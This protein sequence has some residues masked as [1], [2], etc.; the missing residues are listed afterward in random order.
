MPPAITH[1]TKSFVDSLTI[2][3]GHVIMTSHVPQVIGA[4]KF[5]EN[6][7]KW[8]DPTQESIQQLGLFG[9]DLNYHTYYPDVT[10]DELHPKDEEFIHPIFR[11]L[12]AT[13]VSKNWNPTDFGHIEG[14][15][16]N[17]MSLLLGQTV[18]CDHSTDIGNAIGSVS[19]V[20]WQEAYKDGKIFIPAGIN[21]VLKID[22]KANP[23][24]ARGI[25]MEPPS[26]H[27]N[28]VTVQFRW[29]K[30]H[31]ELSDSEFYDK[32]GT[33]DSKGALIRRIVTE[34]IRYHETS[35]VSHGA[36]PYAQKINQ[37]GK[38]NNPIFAHRTWNSFAEY[39]DSKDKIYTFE[40][41]KEPTTNDTP[42]DNNKGET[43]SQK[44]SPEINNNSNPISQMDKKLQAFL[45]SLFGDGRLTLAEGQEVTQENALSAISALVA[46]QANHQEEIDAL[47]E[48]VNNLTTERDSLQ[49]QIASLNDK[50]ANLEPMA[51]IGKN[52]LAS[53][54]EQCVSTYQKLK[55]DDADE[56][57]INMLNAE[58]TGIQTLTSLL[59]DYTTRLNEKF[60][61]KCAECGST[62]V[63]R[64]SSVKEG[65]DEKKETTTN[66][67][68]SVGDTISDLYRS[69]LKN[70]K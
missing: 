67:E 59:A 70:L 41:Y 34:I 39:T 52:H 13:I 56:S 45:E 19:E 58:T 15:L 61:M 36:D 23:R 60:P 66:K 18:N 31:P 69:K 38:L 22:G 28:S 37:D 3:Q 53:L 55:G 17:S 51:N 65:E 35:L 24:I 49:S 47:N 21:G 30:S 26:I 40:D 46:S 48:T 50:V 11:L 44:E 25:L 42:T 43:S 14:V 27:S 32:I 1:K 68:A 20:I 9:S 33:Y 63:S 12:S 8:K 29:E 5:V 57:I 2:G 16:K 64:A 10:A 7:Y 6:Y 62:D 54:R 4:Q